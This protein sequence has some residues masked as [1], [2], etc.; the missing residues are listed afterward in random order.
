MF[1][2]TITGLICTK[3]TDLISVLLFDKIEYLDDVLGICI[4]L[5]RGM[6][7]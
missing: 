3:L 6:N 5:E 1:K 2:I 4:P 7:L